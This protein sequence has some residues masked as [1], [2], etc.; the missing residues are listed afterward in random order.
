[1]L[2]ANQ[3]RKWK[4]SEDVFNLN[5]QFLINRVYSHPCFSAMKITIAS[6]CFAGTVPFLPLLVGVVL[7]MLV[8]TVFVVSKTAWSRRPSPSDVEDPSVVEDLVVMDVNLNR[9]L[10][11]QMLVKTFST[12]NYLDSFEC[13]SPGFYFSFRD[14]A[15]IFVLSLE[16]WVLLNWL[17]NKIYS[18]N[19][20]AG[21][22]C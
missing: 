12:T 6:P 22:T 18:N 3:T 2:P 21:N 11:W 13:S 9:F 17:L 14:L 15:F 20:Q 4:I 5:R 16:P 1:M 8:A 19:N 10:T 7:A